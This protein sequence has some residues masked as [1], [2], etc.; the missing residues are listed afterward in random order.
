MIMKKLFT[1]FAVAVAMFMASCAGAPATPSDAAV[2]YYQY[3]ANG[4]YEAFADAIHFDTTDPEEIA[5]GKAMVVSLYKEKAAPQ[6]EAKSGVKSVEATGETISEDGNTA[7]VQLKVIY[8]D[9]S[10]KTEDVKLVKVENK[11]LLAFDK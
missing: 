10:E 5:E 2:E 11:W 9:G 3:V 8:G 7:N 6:M 4:D 1:L